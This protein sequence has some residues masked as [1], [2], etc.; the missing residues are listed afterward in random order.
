MDQCLMQTVDGTTSPGP[1]GWPILG[2]VPAMLT[3]PLKLFT[4]ST[5][6]FGDVVHLNLA[7]KSAYL[8]TNP[9]YVQRVFTETDLFCK[10]K[11]YERM[12]P[13]V[14]NGLVTSSGAVWRKDRRLC[15]PHFNRQ[16]LVGH[17]L[18]QMVA[19]T[20]E[21]IKLWEQAADNS[22]QVDM[23]E[24][25]RR[26]TLAIV[27]RAL[28]SVDLTSDAKTVAHAL[29]TALDIMAKRVQGAIVFPEWVPTPN[30]IRLRMAIAQL[31]RIVHRLITQGR[32]A[33][34]RGDDFLSVLIDATDSDTGSSLTDSELRDQL[35]T[36]MLAGHETTASSLA[37]SFYLLA[38]HPEIEAKV[39]EEVQ[40]VLG[41]REP[42]GE[43]LRRLTY[44]AMVF[45]ETQRLYPPVWMLDRVPTRDVQF[46]EHHIPAGSF[47]FVSAYINHR[48]PAYWEN[49]EAF[50]PERFSPEQAKQRPAY[51]YFPFG[52]GQ[53]ICIG[54]H[55]AEMEAVIILAMTLRKFHLSLIPGQ[56][57]EVTPKLTLRSKS[58]IH[59]NINRIS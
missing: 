29:M 14:G 26:T 57:I 39:R 10:S 38:Q 15:Q 55:F 19:V 16:R 33:K 13:L 22:E 49:P 1:K 7:G 37:W 21:T 30:M 58:G 53:R 25:M 24:E 23:T 4:E 12:R 8:V 31:D 59:M 28:F 40:S 46:G 45:K 35:M 27:G 43:D 36:F 5:E 18:Q 17:S 11:R 9:A 56:S 41:D 32:A 50:M 3:D 48:L 52:G 42:T 20:N 2:H 34:Q 47:I 51:A 54:N 44:T 6:Q